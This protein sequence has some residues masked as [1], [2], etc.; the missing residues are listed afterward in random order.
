MNGFR[1]TT[2][3]PIARTGV[4]TSSRPQRM[5][6]VKA[7]AAKVLMN[8][9][10]SSP[11]HVRTADDSCIVPVTTSFRKQRH[12]GASLCIS[13]SKH[14][15]PSNP[16][17]PPLSPCKSNL[18]LACHVRNREPS[19]HSPSFTRVEIDRTT[20][21]RQAFLRTLSS[22]PRGQR[23]GMTSPCS[24]QLR[25]SAVSGDHDSSPQTGCFTGRNWLLSFRCV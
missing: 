10:L 16:S 6:A 12:P 21:A 13:A 11:E 20:G 24:P 17:P 2:Y 23:S 4:Y 8:A 3:S 25:S 18:D 22:M 15:Y 9:I 5:A 7:D 1:T 14:I 19:H